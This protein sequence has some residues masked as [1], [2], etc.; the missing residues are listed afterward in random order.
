MAGRA[1]AAAGSVGPAEREGF[2]PAPR[3]SPCGLLA[4]RLG[5]GETPPALPATGAGTVAPG[6][7]TACGAAAG[8]TGA[9]GAGA[10]GAVAGAVAGVPWLTW[11]VDAG[12]E[13]AATGRPLFFRVSSSCSRK[14]TRSARASRVRSASGRAMRVKAISKTRRWLV[15]VLISLEASPRTVRMRESRST[16]PKAAASERRASKSAPRALTTSVAQG[17]AATT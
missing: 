13:G 6:W 10:L 7:A 17:T 8:W 9:A 4:A 15:A 1:G 2:L 11:G 16:E 5:R 14:A 12:W 3:R